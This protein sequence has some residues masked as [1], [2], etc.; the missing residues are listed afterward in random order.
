MKPVLAALITWD[1]NYDADK[2]AP[3]YFEEWFKAFYNDVWDEILTRPE[4][5]RILKPTTWRTIAIL[6]GDASNKF[7]DLQATNDKKE[8]AKDLLASSFKAMTAEIVKVQA[9][10]KSKYPDNPTLNWTH[11]K[12]T[13]IPHIANIPGMGRT[14]IANGGY[15]KSINA[16]KKNHGPSWRMIVE[17]APDRPRA[18][19]VYP[20]GQSGNPGSKYYDQFVDTWTKGEYYEAIFMRKADEKHANLTAVQEFFKAQ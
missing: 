19:V 20:G 11:Y 12:D 3:I 9:E 1:Y 10:I 2:V 8:T 7:F 14:H 17:L 13:E 6:R 16:V 15:A 18:Y 4:K 5:D